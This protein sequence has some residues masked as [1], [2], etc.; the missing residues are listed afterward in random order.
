MINWNKMPKGVMTNM[1]ELR[2]VINLGTLTILTLENVDGADNLRHIEIH[3][4]SFEYKQLKLASVDQQSWLLHMG[5]ECPVPENVMVEVCFRYGKKH[6]GIASDIDWLH[7][8]MDFDV[9]A[10]KIYE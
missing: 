5:G 7:E 9:I 3:S 8:L 6:T 4:E 1:G 10:Y 2:R